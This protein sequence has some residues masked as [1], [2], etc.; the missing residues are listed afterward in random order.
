[1]QNKGFTLVEMLAVVIILSLFGVIGIISVESIIKK[2][3]EKAYNAQI[4]EIK[5]AAENFV[6]VN[7]EPTWCQN[8]DLCFISLRYLVFSKQIKLNESGEFIN[9]KTDKPFALE[10]VAMVKKYGVNYIFEVYDDFEKLNETNNEY[11]NKAKKDA[12]KASALIYKE[13]GLCNED[14]CNLKTS[15]LVSN[16]LLAREFYNEVTIIINFDDEIVI[17]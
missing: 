7:G 3:S 12:L 10:T 1:M 5:N 14:N 8:E 9:P 16:N 4:N 11:Y 2:G 13:K 17:E 15:D 6:K